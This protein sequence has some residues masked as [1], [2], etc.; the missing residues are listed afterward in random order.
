MP[1]APGVQAA[2]PTIRVGDADQPALVQ[3]LLSLLVAEQVNGLY[4][5]EARF[6]NWGSPPAGGGGTA[7]FLYFDRQLLDF[8]KPFSVK[9]GDDVIFDGRIMGLEADFPEGRA[10]E[11]TV[12]AED[13]L[14]DLRMTRRTRTF[15]N[16][17]AA[18]AIRQIASDHGLT[19]EV[20]LPG[21]THKVLAQVNQ[22]DLAFVRDRARAVGAE[23]WIT[24]SALKVKPRA[25]RAG[26]PVRL[27]HGK[28]LRE[29]SVLSDLARQH[30]SLVVSGWDTSAKDAI[31]HE[32]TDQVV[33]GEL[34]GDTSGAA[35]LREAIGERKA[36][37]THTAPATS[38]EAQDRAEAAFRAQARRFLTGRGIAEPNAQLRVGAQVELKGLGPLFDGSYYLADVAHL[39]DGAHGM[40]TE[41]SAERPGIGRA[42]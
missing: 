12:L 16:A 17:S 38:R 35:L 1:D 39:F 42:N 41:F 22:T 26:A 33:Q 27:T 36:S 6:G 13:R 23:V 8:G 3:G 24:G 32:A 34:G 19:A 7:G 31:T 37:V 11:I 25:S 20:D 40:R 14:Q 5:C 29:F 4:R 28:E 18:D 21:P 2:R 9:L 15:E 30:T 10:P